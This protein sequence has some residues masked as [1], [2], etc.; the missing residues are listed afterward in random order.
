MVAFV[1]QHGEPSEATR[2]CRR[3][4]R[5]GV[6]EPTASRLEIGSG[7]AA[8]HETDSPECG[9]DRAHAAPDLIVAQGARSSRACHP[10]ATRRRATAASLLLGTPV[11]NAAVVVVLRRLRKIRL[12][13]GSSNVAFNVH[14]DAN[15]A[16]TGIRLA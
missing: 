10:A 5:L 4:Y 11:V 12:G 2:Q 9:H 14:Q 8:D 13:E 7:C 6:T 3:P 15:S 16:A 1:D